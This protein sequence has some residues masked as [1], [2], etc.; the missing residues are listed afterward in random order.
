[1]V[2]L[3]PILLAASVSISPSTAATRCGGMAATIVGTAGND[4]LVGTSGN[5]VIAAGGG[6]D[7]VEGLKGDDYI[8]GEAGNDWLSAGIGNDVVY[9]GTDRDELQGDVGNDTLYG[10]AGDD[11][12]AGG[13]G[14]DSL[15]GYAG[16]DAYVGGPG[17][18]TASFAPATGPVSVSLLD[19]S[20]VGEGTDSIAGIENVTGSTFADALAGDGLPNLLSGRKGDDVLVGAGEA[21]SLIGGPDDDTVSGGAGNDIV[22]G[23][24]GLDRADYATAPSA[25]AV[26]LTTKKASGG[27]GTD[28]V[29]NIERVTGSA[30]ADTLI[31]D[32]LANALDGGDGADRLR[33]GGGADALDGGPADDVASFV[34]AIR[35]VTVDLAAGRATGEGADTLTA[36]EHVDGSQW[37]D[38]LYGN[39]VTNIL[40]GFEGSDVLMGFDGFDVL[41]GGLGDDT[42]RG[43]AAQ[44]FLH[45]GGGTD[46]CV[47]GE[48]LASCETGGGTLLVDL[49]S[50]FDYVDPALAF[51]SH[52]YQLQAMTCARLLAH[53]DASP[54]E[55][56]QLV[57]D[58]ATGLPSVSPDSRTYTFKIRPGVMF[59]PPSGEVVTAA[60]FK[61]TIERALHPAMQSPAA[62]FLSDV[63]GYDAFRAG[64]AS[65]I[66]GIVATGDRLSISLVAARGDLP[67]RLAMTFFCAVPTS[68]PISPQFSP[69]PSAGPYYLTS[70][71]VGS[72][73]EAARN[74]NYR[75]PRASNFDS[76]D[77]DVGVTP[78]NQRI[79]I[80][81]NTRDVG[82]IPPANA[83]EIHAAYGEGSPA[84]QAGRQR[85]F[86]PPQPV[87][88]Y[89]VLNTS[90]P[91]FADENLRKA[92]AYAIDRTHLASL[93]GFLGGNPTDQILPP[94]I[95]GF[96]D[97][98]M[99]PLTPDPAT[100]Q[101]YAAAA[102]VTPSSPITVELYTFNA[103]QGPGFASHLESAL[104]R[105][106]INVNIQSFDRVVQHEKI[107]TQGEPFDISIE[108]W[109]ADYNDPFN[110]LDMLLNGSRIRPTANLNVSYFNDPT[111][112]ARLDAA[113]PL[114]GPIRLATYADLDR[115]LSAAAPI[116]PYVNTNAR[117]FFSDR[118]GCHV[119]PGG[120]SGTALNALCLR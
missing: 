13:D 2:V 56:S 91:A 15:L 96:R 76:I 35:G 17:V 102:G 51:F 83:A 67:A 73:A 45:G 90:R 94:G 9:G 59:S 109:A 33:G 25:V 44:D 26:D 48:T 47:D 58:A 79:R 110:F 103:G 32:A 6:D 69:L 93:H 39:A 18:D 31:G 104:A 66:S 77:W 60:T 28:S 68:T 29:R 24:T 80:E 42:L 5:D 115:D 4:T 98:N 40:N 49:T 74:P 113:S 36:I 70:R 63:A 16:N 27:D 1:M 88:W 30:H 3:A 43:G 117:A 71:S 62:S 7:R 8:C 55:G 84:A 118:I 111:F 107:A 12:L 53:L 11:E 37:D 64:T 120:L 81:N 57:P 101:S 89:V 82:T 95:S 106:G 97:D 119:F 52:S 41:G 112:N 46:A 21:D 75:G 72:G 34:G 19:G 65:Q 61:F 86:T 100:A 10:Q 22:D 85:Y 114:T 116:V 108:G 78:A 38:F 23:G 87:F 20:A 99:F 14:K 105:L 50:D 92:V 54:P